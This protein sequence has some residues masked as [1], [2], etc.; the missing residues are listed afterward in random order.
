MSKHVCEIIL[1]LD[2]AEYC[3][4]YCLSEFLMHAAQSAIFAIDNTSRQLYLFFAFHL[5]R[6]L[7]HI[8]PNA[9]LSNV[10]FHTLKR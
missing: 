7:P 5:K 10:T 2:E 8:F 1:R 6:L 4:G 3:F 9:I